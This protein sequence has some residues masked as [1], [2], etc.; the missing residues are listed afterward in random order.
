MRMDEDDL[1]YPWEVGE[2]TELDWEQP[3]DLRETLKQGYDETLVR[4]LFER[5]REVTPSEE[6]RE[7]LKPAMEMDPDAGTSMPDE[8]ELIVGDKYPRGGCHHIDA[9]GRP[10]TV[11]LLVDARE[12]IERETG[13]HMEEDE[14]EYWLHHSRLDDLRENMETMARSS[15]D[16]SDLPVDATFC[17]GVPVLGFATFP[18]GACLLWDPERA[19]EVEHAVGSVEPQAVV[20]TRPEHICRIYSIGR[21]DQ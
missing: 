16:T 12:V 13:V 6:E 9:E 18:P 15:M 7:A 14:W 10:A 11:D 8:T 21:P 2:D 5:I 3:K 19:I 17:Y 1:I 20:I 4:H